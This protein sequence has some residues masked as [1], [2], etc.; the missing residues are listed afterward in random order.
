VRKLT[1]REVLLT[2]GALTVAG[3]ANWGPYALGDRFESHLAG[4][5]GLP[6]T[7]TTEL[8][9]ALRSSLGG[10]EYDA[11]A[12]AFVAATT[13]PGAQLMPTALRREAVEGLVGPLMMLQKGLLT[14]YV[15]ADLQKR[16]VPGPCGG[17]QRL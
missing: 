6:V 7:A 8:L 17:V 9:V 14:S 2:G 4:L 1:R 13:F 15:L 10:P 3:G 12:A 16:G 11:R 5:L